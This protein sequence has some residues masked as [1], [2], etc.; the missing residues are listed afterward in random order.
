MLGQK[1]ANMSADSVTAVRNG[2]LAG[3]ASVVGMHAMSAAINNPATAAIIA[4]GGTAYALASSSSVGDALTNTGR[5]VF[6][7]VRENIGEPNNPNNA[8]NA[9]GQLSNFALTTGIA[10]SIATANP[11]FA[12]AGCAIGSGAQ[13]VRAGVHHG[14]CTIL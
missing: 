1:E 2:V 12:I 8:Y 5:E 11:V 7:V 10:A 4:G 13:L 3:A 9:A 14:V 6:H